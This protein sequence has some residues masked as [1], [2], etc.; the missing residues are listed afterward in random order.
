MVKCLLVPERGDDK[1]ALLLSRCLSYT[2]DGVGPRYVEPVI[3]EVGWVS[4]KG[5]ASLGCPCTS[6]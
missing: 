4:A 6:T 2:S 3:A 5:W 1:R